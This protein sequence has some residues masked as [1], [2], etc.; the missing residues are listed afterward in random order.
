MDP[1]WNSIS[2]VAY[3]ASNDESGQI[4]EIGIICLKDVLPLPRGPCILVEVAVV[5]P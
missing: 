3:T 4:P 1:K 2:H 5:S